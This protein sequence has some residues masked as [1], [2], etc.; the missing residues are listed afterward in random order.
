MRTK[1]SARM[2]VSDHSPTILATAGGSVAVKKKRKSPANR[3]LCIDDTG[4]LDQQ[5]VPGSFDD[6]SSMFDDLQ[7]DHV[8]ADRP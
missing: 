5:T 6:P 3:A 4:E 8:G 7:I 1:Q 2:W